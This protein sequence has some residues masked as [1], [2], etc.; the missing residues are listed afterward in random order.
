MTMRD[1]LISGEFFAP[2]H[3]VAASAVPGQESAR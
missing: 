2:G 1:G 3:D